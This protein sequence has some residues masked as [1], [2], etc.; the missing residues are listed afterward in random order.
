[1]PEVATLAAPLAITVTV[2]ELADTPSE[3]AAAARIESIAAAEDTFSANAI[4]TLRLEA[5]AG[6][7][8]SKGLCK[9]QR[10][11]KIAQL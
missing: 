5:A 8:E 7:E 9:M 1:M 4:S 6:P 3:A 11:N 10:F 2:T